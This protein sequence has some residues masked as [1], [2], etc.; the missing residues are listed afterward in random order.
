MRRFL[1]I[2]N[3]YRRCLK[4]AAK[5]QAILTEF[6]KD[7][8]KHDGRLV[9]WTPKAEEA[10]LNCKEELLKIT[11]LTHPAPSVPLILTCDASDFAVGASLEQIVDGD[12]KP[13]AF[14]SRKLN[15]S[16]RSYSA[17]D[18]ELLG[19]YLAIKYF[20]YFLERRNFIIKTDHKP[21]IYAAE[22]R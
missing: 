5:N 16:Q 19:I 21:L 22:T 4:N 1:G 7:S 3:Y 2:I 12:I 11:T 13:I 10:F 9:P 18:R 14:F 17:Y 20:R 8:R 15:S 6:L